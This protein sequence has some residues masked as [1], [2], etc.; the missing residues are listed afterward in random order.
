MFVY[1]SWGREDSEGRPKSPVDSFIDA[2]I[3]VLSH[4]FLC[5]RVISRREMDIGDFLE[6]RKDKVQLEISQG[7]SPLLL[8][9]RGHSGGALV[10]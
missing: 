6:Y 7:P 8:P 10:S 4:H 2:I 5:E 9:S 3:K 1:G